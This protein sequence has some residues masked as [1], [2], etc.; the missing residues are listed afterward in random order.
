MLPDIKVKVKNMRDKVLSE[1]V[2]RQCEVSVATTPFL[3]FLGVEIESLDWGEFTLA[4][5]IRPEHLQQDGFVHAGVQ[6]T[7]ADH[8]CG[9]AAMT[10]MQ[11]HERV[12]SIEFKL[13][14]L[15]PAQGQRLLAVARVIRP[16][17]RITVVE[18]DVLCLNDGKHYASA[19]MLGTMAVVE[20]A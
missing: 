7:L 11:A 6:A 17:R 2:R 10:C 13:N 1:T 12:L 9:M 20:Q 16:G 19:R 5:P 8:A 4:M 3:Q 15:K 14:L 18:A